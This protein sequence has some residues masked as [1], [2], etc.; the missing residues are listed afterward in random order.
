ME[1]DYEIERKQRCALNAARLKEFNIPSAVNAV[2]E[3]IN[4]P[5]Y[6]RPPREKN[7]DAKAVSDVAPS[8]RITRSAATAKPTTIMTERDVATAGAGM[9]QHAK[10]TGMWSSE[11]GWMFSRL[12]II[13]SIDF[14]II[15]IVIINGTKRFFVILISG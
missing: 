6:I 11:I 8:T 5:R 2:T 10:K 14:Q 4:K 9:K 13:S 15:S 12:V 7:P 1:S 3:L